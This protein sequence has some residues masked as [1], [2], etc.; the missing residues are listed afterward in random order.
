MNFPEKNFPQM[1][2]YRDSR[3]IQV[4]LNA[5]SRENVLNDDFIF[6]CFRKW[7][8]L[9]FFSRGQNKY[10]TKPCQL[11]TAAQPVAL[12]MK[13]LFLKGIAVRNQFGHK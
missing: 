8:L 9:L 4:A 11:G 1:I 13:I 12:S 2:N 6:A 3:F 5:C 10:Y 7:I